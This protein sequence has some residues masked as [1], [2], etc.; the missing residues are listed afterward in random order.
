[1]PSS[2][3]LR[4]AALVTA[5]LVTGIG[6]ASWVTRTPAIRD[7][8]DASTAEIGL[9]LA[10]LSAGSMFGIAF[11]AAAVARFGGRA[12]IVVGLASVGVG[13][14]LMAAGS[15]LGSAAGVAAGLAIFGFGMGFGEIGLNVEGVDVEIAMG[16]SVVPLLH[17]C[18]SLGTFVGALLGLAANSAGV[19]VVVHLGVVAAGILLSLILVIGG[20][21]AGTGRSMRGAASEIVP[22][23]RLSWLDRRTLALA[24]I[25][26]GMALAEGS[27][28]DWLPLIVVDGFRLD[29]AAGSLI[30]AFFGLAMAIGRI[31][32]GFVIDRVD[33]AMV[34]RVCA[35]LAAAGI[36]LVAFSPDIVG[37]AFGVLM[38]GVGAALGFPVA[39]SA[40]GDDPRFAARRASFVATAGYT[41][42][43][44]GP[45]L[46]G[47][48]AEHFTLRGAIL[49]VLV[50]VLGTVAF[51]GALRSG[52]GAHPVA[53]DGERSPAIRS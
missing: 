9:I 49:I 8:L 44:V 34:M 4:R 33:R 20:T 19:P 32:G 25:I 15:M 29:A 2:P 40:A 5:F 39:L 53:P 17:G 50:A 23:R 24:C 36:A 42:F 37:A 11:G 22:E 7:A 51:S 28:S 45:P 47:F 35:V 10:A 48:A 14:A 41:A 46:L 27:A 16:R 6:M 12:V 31:G 26:L 3:Q 38:W 13:V 21:V 30:Y 1:M 43:L 52:R 18:Y